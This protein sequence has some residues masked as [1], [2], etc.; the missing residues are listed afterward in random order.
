MNNATKDA[1]V[2]Y[3]AA[4]RSHRK[5]LRAWRAADERNPTIIHWGEKAA[6][7]STRHELYHAVCPVYGESEACRRY[8]ALTATRVR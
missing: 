7:A 1:I 6:V 5:A 2:A 4:V 8:Y 3:R